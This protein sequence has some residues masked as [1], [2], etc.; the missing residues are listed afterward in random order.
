MKN[1]RQYERMYERE[2]KLAISRKVKGKKEKIN[3]N[4]KKK[5]ERWGGKKS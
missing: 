1:W 4:A 3:D 2:R 5:S